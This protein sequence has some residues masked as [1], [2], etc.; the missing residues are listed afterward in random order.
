MSE[1][2]KAER[3][4]DRQVGGNH[5]RKVERFMRFVNKNGPVC[6]GRGKCWVHTKMK[7]GN[8]SRLSYEL[9][10]GPRNGL[11]VCHHCDNPNCV[12]PSHLFLGTNNDNRQDS[13]Q[14]RRHA[15]GER[16]GAAKLTD[17]QIKEIRRRYKRTSYHVSNKN[18][19]A[20]EFNIHPEYLGL[21]VRNT[22]RNRSTHYVS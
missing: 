12:R 3:A 20:R 17:E 13:V 21:I 8:K 18:E 5:Y 16:H 4:N 2:E 15:H 7:K 14:K 19:L 6:L 10:I 9:F 11:F 1:G 22:Y